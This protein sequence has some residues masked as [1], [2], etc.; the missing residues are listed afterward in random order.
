MLKYYCIEI[1]EDQNGNT[2]T[3]GIRYVDIVRK[4]KKLYLK[5]SALPS[6]YCKHIMYLFKNDYIRVYNKKDNSL[7]FEGFYQSV[8]NV[9]ESRYKLKFNNLAKEVAKTISSKDIVKKFDVSI[10]GR[11]GGEIKCSEPLSLI[12]EKK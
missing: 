2:K 11:I 6:D 8:F 1:Y 5:D 3:Y 9:N 4:N 7:K 10:L 12:S